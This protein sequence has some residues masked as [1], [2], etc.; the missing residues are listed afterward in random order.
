MQ[1]GDRRSSTRH[2][3]LDWIVCVRTLHVEQPIWPIR[4][5][6]NMLDIMF[7][8][9]GFSGSVGTGRRHSMECPLRL[10]LS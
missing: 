7:P 9:R 2:H 8:I 6:V 1:F 3:I 4:D 5:R 10:H